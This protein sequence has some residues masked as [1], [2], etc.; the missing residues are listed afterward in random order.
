M[1][2]TSQEKG[3]PQPATPL[4]CDNMTETGIAN[5]TIKKQ[6]SR[7]MEMRFI[8][9]TDQVKSGVMDIHWHSGQETLADYKI[10]H[11]DSKYHQVV[12][13]WYIQEDNSP[14][15][16]TRAAKPSALRGCVGTVSNGYNCTCPLPRIGVSLQ[17]VDKVPRDRALL[18]TRISNYSTAREFSHGN[19]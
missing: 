10:K 5:N 4:H 11:H 9:V 15:E 1:Q 19:S 14:R 3:H 12:C 18:H 6:H 8:W 13:P 16:L 7:S 2:L 17:H